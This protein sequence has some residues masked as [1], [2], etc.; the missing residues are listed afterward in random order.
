MSW[1]YSLK[2]FFRCDSPKLEPRLG[3]FLLSQR[4]FGPLYSKQGAQG[5]V[6][7]VSQ[8]L[9][10]EPI[11][12]DPNQTKPCHYWKPFQFPVDPR[13]SQTCSCLLS[14]RQEV[15]LSL[16]EDRAQICDLFAY[17]GFSLG[18]LISTFGK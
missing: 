18:D 10:C 2:G 8:G 3:S 4:L 7:S 6:P 12:W 5:H 16:G 1:T 11:V 9:P 15:Q 17:L 14:V 13:C